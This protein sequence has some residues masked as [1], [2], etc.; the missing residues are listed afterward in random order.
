MSLGNAAQVPAPKVAPDVC[1]GLVASFPAVFRDS[2][3]LKAN[4]YGRRQLL[5]A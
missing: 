3:S 1:D 2:L 4:R 5:K